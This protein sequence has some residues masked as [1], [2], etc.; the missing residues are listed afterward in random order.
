MSSGHNTGSF[1]KTR[2]NISFADLPVINI[3]NMN[4]NKNLTDNA[5]S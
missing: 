4:V 1:A 3:V 2:D 5:N